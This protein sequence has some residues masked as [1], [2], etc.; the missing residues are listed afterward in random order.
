MTVV[1]AAQVVPFVYLGLGI[2]QVV[3]KQET[4]TRNLVLR[5]DSPL[6][7]RA[8]EKIVFRT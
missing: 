1:H 2:V 8:S 3:Q 6:R 7:A 5:W 4:R